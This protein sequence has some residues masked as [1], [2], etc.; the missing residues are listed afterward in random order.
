MLCDWKSRLV[1]RAASF[2]LELSGHL[3]TTLVSR[4]VGKLFVPCRFFES[5]LVQTGLSLELATDVKL[6]D[7]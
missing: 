6:I 4:R 3:P 5:P 7:K 1:Q 2:Y